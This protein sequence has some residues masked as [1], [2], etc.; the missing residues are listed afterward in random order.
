MKRI[1]KYM[2]A[3]SVLAGSTTACDDNFLQQDPFQNLA[4]GSFLKNEGD[5]PI[6]LNGL[7]AL[8]AE[9]HQS[10]NAY[11]DVA[12]TQMK[13]SPI[14]MPDLASDN[15]VAFT[16]TAGNPSARLDG[17]YKTPTDGSKTANG[18]D[19]TSLKQVNY[20]L[21]HVHDADGS[22][23]DPSALNKWIAEACFFKAWDY[24]KKLYIFGEVPWFDLDLNVDSPELYAPRTPRVELADSILSLLNFAVANIKDGGA[25]DGRINRD[26]V[27]F[28]KARFCLFEGTFRKYHTELGLQSSANKFLAEV[29]TA[30][31]AIIATNRYELFKAKAKTPSYPGTVIDSYWQM[32]GQVQSPAAD[33]NKEAI[34]AR[35]YDGPEGKLGHGMSRYYIMNRGNASGRYSKGAT[36]S[37]IEDYLCIDGQTIS[38]SPLFKGY[39]GLWEE[40]DNRD[41]RLTQTVEKP[42]TYLT[43][44]D[45][46]KATLSLAD[47][48]LKYPEITYNCPTAN[49]CVT[50]GP[51]VT[52]YYIIKHMTTD[53]PSNGSTA[54]GRQTAVMFRYG[55]VLLMLAEAKAELGTLTS[56]D[57]DRTVNQLRERAGFDFATYPNSRLTTTNAPADPRLDAI[58]AS[59]VD[60][61]VTPLL[62]EIRRERRVEMAQEGLRR[63][64]LVRWKAGKLMEVPLR[65]MKFTA[66]KQALYNGSNVG[67]VVDGVKIT[68]FQAKKDIDVF[69]DTDGFIIGFPKSPNVTN[70]T[71]KWEDRYYYWPI[72]LEELELNKKLTQNPGWTD[73]AR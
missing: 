34:L 3:A 43:I 72:P 64:D 12:P 58:W 4:E 14:A 52:G 39:D 8:Y 13:G 33:G 23:S 51:S 53:L 9:G 47:N 46:D 70:G 59:A 21:K 61:S 67:K 19:W 24:Y 69:V 18:W 63:E 49:Q 2:F 56:G 41:P 15:A 42:G 11:D 62:R 20:F 66:E 55:E 73:I 5:L 45:R 68:A 6:Y 10:G 38:T 44:F 36:K 48:G 40:L 31:E 57:L 27:N 65:G 54:K 30:C 7:Y 28:L 29:E 37:F 1:V 32:F 22:V 35:V 71:L 60:Y 16:G 25:A 26:M 17:T 50:G